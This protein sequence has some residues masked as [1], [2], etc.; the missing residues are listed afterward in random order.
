MKQEIL[1]LLD[2]T[3]LA[4]A[5]A[6]YGLDA[7]SL[8]PIGDGWNVNAVF[9]CTKGDQRYVLRLTHNT[10]RDY[11]GI[12]AE[13][14]FVQFLGKNGGP[15]AG[16]VS[17]L[18]GN[19]AEVTNN[20]FTAVLFETAPGREVTRDDWNDQLFYD[21]GK[22]TGKLHALSRTY[23][24]QGDAVRNHWDQEEWLSDYRRFIPADQTLVL[25]RIDELLAKLRALPVT[26]D[27]YGLVHGDLHAGNVFI[28]DN[29]D[30]TMIDFDDSVY[31]WFVYDLAMVFY[32]IISRLTRPP[33]RGEGER[34]VLAAALTPFMAG[35]RT[36]NGIDDTLW[37]ALPDFLRL[38]RILLY[39]FYHQNLDMSRISAE[40]AQIIAQT[41]QDIEDDFPTTAFDFAQWL[42]D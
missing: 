28:A 17:S 32:Y 12:R 42:K 15:V 5:A 23:T 38:R 34:E 29:G 40:R 22:A 16:V 10:R 20:G 6:K 11:A 39:V 2:D 37:L 21:W 9:S 41:R 25:R 8:K 30:L 35:Y 18:A 3:V 33:G 26:P 24:A 14:D 31:G 7:G 27:G 13:A 19:S 1:D 36:E 4:T